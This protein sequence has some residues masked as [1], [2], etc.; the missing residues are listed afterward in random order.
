MSIR[1][2]YIRRAAMTDV[3]G[4]RVMQ[5]KSMRALGGRYY[6]PET[7]NVFMRQI[8]TMDDAVVA[9]GHFFVA[10]DLTGAC[11]GSGGW[12]QR[13][14]SYAAH[15]GAAMQAMPTDRAIVRSVFVDPD[16][17]RCGLG[18]ALMRYIENDARRWRIGELALTAT[19]SGVDFYRAR[20]YLA[21]EAGAIDLGDDRPFDY[22]EMKK[23]LAPES[24]ERLA[25]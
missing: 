15:D 20:G 9:E 24:D 3:P 18:S 1:E 17:S 19:L 8:S 10:V 11:V 23:A 4:M 6:A 22:V 21:L 14:P 7:L 13:E 5:E 2:F 16:W 25:S 12:S